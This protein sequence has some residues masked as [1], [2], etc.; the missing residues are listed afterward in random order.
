[1]TRSQSS[2]YVNTHTSST[3]WPFD[4][5]L[6]N[7]LWLYEHTISQGAQRYNGQNGSGEADTA[8]IVPWVR[9]EGLFL[10]GP[11][12]GPADT[13]RRTCNWRGGPL[14][15]DKYNPVKSARLGVLDSYRVPLDFIRTF[16]WPKSRSFKFGPNGPQDYDQYRDAQGTWSCQK[17]SPRPISRELIAVQ[18]RFQQC[19]RKFDPDSA[20]GN[21]KNIFSS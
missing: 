13:S 14:A 19:P 3:D 9:N 1:M 5:M 15:D 6:S 21:L 8:S 4:S 18:P 12:S 11:H 20:H 2:K 16:L 17:N 7:W 10:H